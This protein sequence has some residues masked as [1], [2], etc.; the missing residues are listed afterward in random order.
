MKLTTMTKFALDTNVLIYNHY[1]ENERKRDIAHKLLTMSPIISAQVVSEYIN[2]MKRLLPT[3]KTNLMDLCIQWMEKCEIHPVNISTLR[4]AK[5]IIQC[6][7][8]QI[9]DSIIVAS[10]V[11][12]NCEILY[13]ED[14]H[15][16]LEIDGRLKIL[17]PFL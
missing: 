13:S 4:I 17:N 10:A 7:D 6:Y 16:G 3:S 8:L 9:F 1:L 5:H 12:A 2:V 11:E 15:H 14:M